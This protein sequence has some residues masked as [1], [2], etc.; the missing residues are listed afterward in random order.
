MIRCKSLFGLVI[1]NLFLVLS[2]FTMLDGCCY[3]IIAGEKVE[4]KSQ[5]LNYL[6]MHFKQTTKSDLQQ[7]LNQ[8]QNSQQNRIN[9]KL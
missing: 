2:F 4:A 7:K 8:Q 1:L 9:K 5:R 3:C 6:I